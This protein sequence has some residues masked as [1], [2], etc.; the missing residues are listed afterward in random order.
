MS[1]SAWNNASDYGPLFMPVVTAIV[2]VVHIS[3]TRGGLGQ[4]R[5]EERRREEKK[6]V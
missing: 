1:S 5:G 2:A 6:A 3:R 4:R